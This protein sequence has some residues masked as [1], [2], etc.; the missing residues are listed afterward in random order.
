MFSAPV[1]YL[2][3]PYVIYRTRDPQKLPANRYAKA[4]VAPEAPPARSR[5]V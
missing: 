1:G 2:V 4:W 5:W 3:R